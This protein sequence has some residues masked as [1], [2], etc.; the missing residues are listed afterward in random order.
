VTRA[1]AF[2]PRTQLVGDRI[3]GALD[4][5]LAGGAFPV[6]PVVDWLRGDVTGHAILALGAEARTLP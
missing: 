4:P 6:S 2:I 5:S 1:R 3:Y